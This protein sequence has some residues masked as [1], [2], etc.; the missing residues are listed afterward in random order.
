MV[1]P[2]VTGIRLPAMS[3]G[4]DIGGPNEPEQESSP[5]R[6]GGSS[7]RRPLILKTPLAT[8]RSSACTRPCANAIDPV[9]CKACPVPYSQTPSGEGPRQVDL[10]AD[11][12]QELVAEAGN[13]EPRDHR[14]Q[15]VAEARP[16]PPWQ[17]PMPLLWRGSTRKAELEA[18]AFAAQVE[19]SV[20]TEFEPSLAL[21]RRGEAGYG[22]QR[23]PGVRR[24]T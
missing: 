22:A 11:R 16:Q 14:Q 2:P 10:Q 3:R 13:Y 12:R 15:H 6:A 1:P 5:A 18:S 7:R 20:H 23:G 4:S 8:S 17:I 24:R 9:R 19:R 21:P